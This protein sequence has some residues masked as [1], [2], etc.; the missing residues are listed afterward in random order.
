MKKVDMQHIFRK[1]DGLKKLRNREEEILSLQSTIRNDYSKYLEI[2]HEE[3]N[4][5]YGAKVSNHKSRLSAEIEYLDSRIEFLSNR[6]MNY[7]QIA[8]SKQNSKQ[9]EKNLQWAYLGV[10]VA[11]FAAMFSKVIDF[12]KWM[13]GKSKKN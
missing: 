9:Q 12:F 13:Y 8:F 1:I 6:N 4:S 5:T 11:I 3:T 7:L 2:R 10:I